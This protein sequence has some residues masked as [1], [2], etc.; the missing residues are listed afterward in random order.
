[1]DGY[2]L[3][4]AFRRWQE[5]NSFYY[6]NAKGQLVECRDKKQLQKLR[7]KGV[8][9]YCAE[10]FRN[11]VFGYDNIMH[12]KADNYNNDVSK[13]KRLVIMSGAFAEKSETERSGAVRLSEGEHTSFQLDK[14]S[15]VIFAQRAIKGLNHEGVI[16]MVNGCARQG[17][18]IYAN[19]FGVP[20]G[21]FVTYLPL[22]PSGHDNAD[23]AYELMKFVLV[24]AKN[25]K[26]FSKDNP[27]YVLGI[28]GGKDYRQ[29]T[30]DIAEKDSRMKGFVPSNYGVYEYKP[31]SITEIS[32]SSFED[33]RYFAIFSIPQSGMVVMSP[34][35]GNYISKGEDIV[36][37]LDSSIEKLSRNTSQ[38]IRDKALAE[39]ELLAT[40]ESNKQRKAE[41]KKKKVVCVKI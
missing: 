24:S 14:D 12:I 13:G 5:L 41:K 1:M 32:K 35:D 20:L 26:E 3:R 40:R 30:A 18:K 2:R 27:F 22:Q 39:E 34:V 15:V 29:T 11:T 10:D 37:P 8:E 33:Q 17:A 23:S 4:Q 25:A 31:S 36:I 9:L 16:E 21:D 38:K 19:S 28:H 6:C 7:A